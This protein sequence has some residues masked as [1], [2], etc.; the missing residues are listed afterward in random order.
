MGWLK[1]LFSDKSDSNYQETLKKNEEHITT[2]ER[3]ICD[4]CGFEIYG[5]QKTVSKAGKI[6][7]VKPCWRKLQKMAKKE[8]FG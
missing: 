5:E 4:F 6:Y 3:N 1:K 8:A 7:H 2:Q